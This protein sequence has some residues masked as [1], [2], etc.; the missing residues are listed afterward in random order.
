M[1]EEAECRGYGTCQSS[2]RCIQWSKG[3]GIDSLLMERKEEVRNAGL[4]HLASLRTQKWK[5]YLSPELAFRLCVPAIQRQLSAGCHK[6]PRLPADSWEGTMVDGLFHVQGTL[7]PTARWQMDAR[8]SSG[9][10]DTMVSV[11]LRVLRFFH[12]A[13][14]TSRCCRAYLCRA[15]CEKG[16]R[17]PVQGRA[18]MHY[19]AHKSRESP[20][21]DLLGIVIL[22]GSD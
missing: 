7:G 14:D 1:R 20:L 13:V 4:L 8:T 19:A 9:D 10:L 2:V 15:A 17:S 5:E 3:R 21:R 22:I 12:V 16:A 18:I 6:P 11:K